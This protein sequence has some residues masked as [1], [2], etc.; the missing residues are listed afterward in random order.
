VAIWPEIDVAESSARTGRGLMSLTVVTGLAAEARIA[1]ATHVTMIVGAGRA[2]RL[3]ADLEMAIAG[4]AR[5]LVSFGIAGALAP[6]LQ[7]GDLLVAEGVQDGARRFSCDLPWRAAIIQRLQESRLQTSLDR[8]RGFAHHGDFQ[9]PQWAG[10]FR[11]ASGRHWAPVDNTGGAPPI[12]DIVGV[13]APLASAADK[14]AVAVATG[15]AAVD[16]ESA[17]VARAAQ[18]HNLPFVVLRVVAD[19]AHRPLPSAALVAMREDGEIDL[20]AV[21]GAFA[22]DPGQLLA[23]VRLGRDSRSAFSTL[24]QARER[25][26]A[27]FAS[28]D[29]RDVSHGMASLVGR[30]TRHFEDV[31]FSGKI[32]CPAF[33]TDQETCEAPA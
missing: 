26:G 23:L 18:R 17:I 21:L 32:A 28:G 6:H 2:R 12:A 8:G 31:G 5:R 14:A 3:A 11:V 19:P 13:D 24:V 1:V 30:N 4:G 15:A 25:L 7:A 10:L 20:S 16:M 9:D 29:L 22:R 27:D 33:L